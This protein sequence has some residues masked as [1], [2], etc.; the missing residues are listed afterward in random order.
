MWGS[1]IPV[2][3]MRAR[4]PPSSPEEKQSPQSHLCGVY[5]PLA[6]CQGGRSLIGHLILALQSP[7]F[8]LSLPPVLLGQ[9]WPLLPSVCP[10]S[11]YRS[12]GKYLSVPGGT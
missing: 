5:L 2:V 1:H 8:P 12:S 11:L 6:I 9:C 4:A 3:G 7:Q 10:I